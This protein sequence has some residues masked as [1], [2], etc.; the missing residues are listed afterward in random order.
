MNKTG[1]FYKEKDYCAGTRGQE[2]RD[3]QENLETSIRT[4]DV[5]QKTVKSF[6]QKCNAN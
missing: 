5:Q 6:D 4:L 2:T 1:V 3:K